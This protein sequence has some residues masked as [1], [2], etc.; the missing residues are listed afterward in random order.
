[1]S[2]TGSNVRALRP[3]GNQDEDATFPS[4][5]AERYIRF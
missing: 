3:S 4:P 5:E 1:M 2:V